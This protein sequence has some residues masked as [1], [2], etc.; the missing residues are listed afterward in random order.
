MLINNDL[1]VAWLVY[2][3]A[4]IGFSAIVWR[5][6]R[7]NKAAWLGYLLRALVLAWLFTPY[8][9]LT[10]EQHSQLAPAFIVI[11]MELLEN[12]ALISTALYYL[13]TTS[14][15]FIALAVVCYLVVARRSSD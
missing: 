15:A 14:G 4:A 7:F 8:Y 3:L 1:L 6:T 12:K 13:I 2:L 11:L 9:W 10:N 5:L